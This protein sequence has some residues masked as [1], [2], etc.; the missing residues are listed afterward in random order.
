MF[1][2]ILIPLD[3]SHSCLRARQIAATISEKFGSRIT[4]IHVMSHDFMHPELKSSYNLSPLI[5]EE[6]DEAYKKAGR[7]ILDQ[8]EEFFNELGIKIETILEKAE[9]PADR[10][11]ERIE[12]LDIDLVVMG[13]IAEKTSSRYSLGSMAEKVSLH[14]PCSVLVAKRKT[15]INKLLVAYDKSK[16]ANKALKV[17]VEL[18]KRFENAKMTILNVENAELHRLEPEIAEEVG[19][20][21]LKEAST[22]IDGVVCD[23]RLEF[24]KPSDMILKIAKM[25]DYDLILLGSRGLSGIK[26]FFTGSVSTDVSINSERSVMLVR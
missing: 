21:V 11:L 14:A 22:S 6:L 2:S 16:D 9:N 10:I 25:E 4:A 26:R 7:K 15:E 5:L 18:C 24:G 1:E 19:E 23:T 13:N 20:K 12:Q 8:A 17:G 3:G